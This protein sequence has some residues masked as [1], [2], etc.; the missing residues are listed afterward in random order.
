MS[1]RLLIKSKSQTQSLTDKTAGK[2]NENRNNRKWK[3]GN[4]RN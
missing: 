3:M 4:K 2:L 1:G